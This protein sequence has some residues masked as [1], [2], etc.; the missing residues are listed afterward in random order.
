MKLYVGYVEGFKQFLVQ[1]KHI[2]DARKE[3]A[4]R[5]NLHNGVEDKND[6]YYFQQEDVDVILVRF[7]KKGVFEF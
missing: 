4:R 2:R 5:V 6:L 1:A 7:D 3:I